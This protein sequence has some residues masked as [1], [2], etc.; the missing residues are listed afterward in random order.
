MIGTVYGKAKVLQLLSAG[1]AG[2]AGKHKVAVCECLSCGETFK[3]RASSLRTGVTQSCGAARCR[4]TA[5]RQRRKAGAGRRGRGPR[6]L[7]AVLKAAFAAYER[8]ERV[9]DVAK[10]AGVDPRKLYSAMRVARECGDV[11]QG[12]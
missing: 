5:S 6:V 11:P 12:R 1:D 4:S 7:P 8:G 3:A 9:V 2:F 10:A